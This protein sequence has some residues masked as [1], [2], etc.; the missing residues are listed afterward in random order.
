MHRHIFTKKKKNLETKLNTVH[1]HNDVD[2][3]AQVWLC[4]C[5]VNQHTYSIV[6]AK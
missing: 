1:L 3:W 4:I 5:R 6:L 2:A